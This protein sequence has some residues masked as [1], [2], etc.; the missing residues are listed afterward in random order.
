[1]KKILLALGTLLVFIITGF[2]HH[3][4]AS[5]KASLW[6]VTDKDNQEWCQF[7]FYTTQ[8]DS[9]L[10]EHKEILQGH[11][12]EFL[13]CSDYAISKTNAQII[14]QYKIGT[15]MGT[16]NLKGR[17]ICM[18]NEGIEIDCAKSAFGKQQTGSGVKK[19]QGTQKEMKNTGS[20]V[21]KGC[22]INGVPANCKTGE[23]L[24]V[25]TNSGASLGD[26]SVN[27]KS[28]DCTQVAEDAW[29]F[30]KMGLWAILVFGVLCLV[31]FVF[32]LIM[33]IHACSNNIPNKILW[34]ALLVGIGLIG[35]GL[36]I[37]IVYYF[38]VKRHC[39][40]S[41]IPPANTQPYQ[42]SVTVGYHE[43]PVATTPFVAPTPPTTTPIQ[44]VE[45]MIATS[46]AETMS[47]TPLES[48][49]SVAPTIPSN[50]NNTPVQNPPSTNA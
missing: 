5:G 45:S 18:N 3:I 24:I 36:V 49:S 43:G 44:T 15:P 2:S 7:P 48:N 37:A 26:C 14:E 32:W 12:D 38:V 27:G 22:Y 13:P 34:I 46:G 8:G 47:Q 17:T 16:A 30:L 50:Q 23:R 39:V 40:A 10:D 20:T 33:L 19:S 29:G 6:I 9:I 28:V 42:A 21:S 35:G 41:Y 31:S 1:M 4:F 11:A 25:A